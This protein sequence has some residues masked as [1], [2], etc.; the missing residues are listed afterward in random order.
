MN[1]LNFEFIVCEI[2]NKYLSNL[3][4]NSIDIL[5]NVQ[6]PFA[7]TSLGV[8]N[9]GDKTVLCSIIDGNENLGSQSL[10]S[11]RPSTYSKFCNL[12]LLSNLDYEKKNR[13]RLT[14]DV[15]FN[16]GNNRKKRQ[17]YS[18]YCIKVRQWRGGSSHFKKGGFPTQS[19]GGV[20]TICSHSIAL[21]VWSSKRNGGF[22]PPEHPLDLPMQCGMIDNEAAHHVVVHSFDVFYHLNLPFD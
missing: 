16:T 18:M 9:Q 1:I 8:E 7:V 20:P 10:F 3:I 22:Q 13:Y 11:I 17:I 15:A 2:H 14:V 19:K 6:V 4:F 5:E 21:I 12:T